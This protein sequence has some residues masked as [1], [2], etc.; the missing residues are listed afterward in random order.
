M[1]NPF[2]GLTKR[3]ALYIAG[4]VASLVALAIALG[5]FK[6]RFAAGSGTITDVP[7]D[8]SAGVGGFSSPG[9]SNYNM[10]PINPVQ[11]GPSPDDNPNA[12]CGCNSPASMGCAGPSQLDDGSANMPLAQLLSYYQSINPVYIQAQQAQLATYNA[13]FAMGES[14]SAGGS[15]VAV[16]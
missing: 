5:G 13:Y 1:E 6:N 14:Y 9:Y 11:L 7:Q 16:S 2:K 8:A 3:D 4:G 12:D 10:P 15:P